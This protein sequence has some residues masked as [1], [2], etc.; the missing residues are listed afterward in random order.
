MIRRYTRAEMG[1]VWSEEARFAAMLRVE[2]AVAKAQV[3]RGTVPAEAYA[4]IERR[5]RVD[6]ERIAEIER[7]TDHDVIAFVSQVAESVGPEGRFLHLGLTSSDVVDSGLALQLR[8]AGTLLLAGAD[9]LLAALVARARAEAGTVMMGR[10]H[11]VHAEPTTLGLKLAGWAFELDRDRA[12]LARAFDDIATGKISGPVGTYS[13]LAPDLEAEVL[14]DLGLAADPVS[15]QIV[16]RDRHAAVMAA[17]A[18]TGGSLERF[19]T[20]VRNLQHTEIGELM[21]PFRAGQKGSSAMPHK[22]NPIL[23]ERIAGLARLLR[24]YAGAAFENQPLWHERDISH[25]SAERVLLP[26]ATILLDYMLAKMTGLVQ[27]LVVRP[28]RMRENIDRGL[29]LHASSRVLVA[30]VEEG[31]LSREEAYTII[32][33]NAMRAADERR[34]LRDL[35]ATDAIVAQRLTL[36]RLDACFEDAGFLVHVP[37][38]IARLDAIDP[39]TA[40]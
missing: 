34:P 8:A 36:A 38:V 3:F 17:I 16:Q 37:A 5:A 13:Q 31:G 19:A 2:L 32:Q 11:S 9:R 28:D 35:L 39:A 15:T 30:L 22:R 26:D 18:I 23:C 33:R 10:T 20:E 25:S 40:R 24:G 12:R 4:A 6:V 27:G 1:A 14:A 21:E 29:G 7:T